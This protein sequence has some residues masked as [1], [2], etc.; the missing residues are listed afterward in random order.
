MAHT[1]PSLQK[2][3]LLKKNDSRSSWPALKKALQLVVDEMPEHEIGAEPPDMAYV[4]SGYAP[5][6]VRLL[7]LMSRPG[8]AAREDALRPLPGKLF[9][10][11]QAPRREGGAGADE[12][13][14]AAPPEAEPASPVTL[15]FFIGGCTYAELAAV[16]WLGRHESPPRQYVVATTHMCSGDAMIKSVMTTLENNL[17]RI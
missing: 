14:A 12:A 11:T 13:E 17:K 5:L 15:V 4:Y 7:G 6:S 1:L 2:L 10:A 3:G 9:D 8:W 16:R